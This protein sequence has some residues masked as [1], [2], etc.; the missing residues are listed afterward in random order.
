MDEK[1]TSDPG[2][3]VLKH[4]GVWFVSDRFGHWTRVESERSS[5]EDVREAMTS[6]YRQGREAAFAELRKLIGAKP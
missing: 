4:E 6:M 3:T 5:A 1:L 2:L